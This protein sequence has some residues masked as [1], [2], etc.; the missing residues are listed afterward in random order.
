[1][2]LRRLQK[3]PFGSVVFNN[4]HDHGGPHERVIGG[5]YFASWTFAGTSVNVTVDGSGVPG[6]VGC[7]L[8]CTRTWNPDGSTTD[9]MLGIR[10]LNTLEDV[11]GDAGQRGL[12]PYPDF[13]I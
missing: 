2:T 11:P 3:C 13:Q 1:M 9:L 6:R 5:H 10:S 4:A 12:G 7:E 8:S